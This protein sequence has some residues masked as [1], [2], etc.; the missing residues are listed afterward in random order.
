MGR[1]QWDL[2]KT[3]QDAL[4]DRLH[5]QPQ[6]GAGPLEHSTCL[7]QNGDLVREEVPLRRGWRIALIESCQG[8]GDSTRRSDGVAV[9][10]KDLLEWRPGGFLQDESSKLA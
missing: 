6:M 8:L 7:L 3:R 4:D 10:V 2:F 5:L 1:S 9:P